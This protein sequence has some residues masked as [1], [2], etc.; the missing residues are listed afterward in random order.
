MKRIALAPLSAEAFAP[1]GDLID[2]R[3]ACE[4]YAING[5]QTRRFHA[6]GRADC[7]TDAGDTIFSIFRSQP[8]SADFKLRT[9][10]RHPLGSQAFI[11]TSGN[12]YAIVVAPAGDLDEDAIRGFIATPQQSINYHRGTWHHFL[13]ALDAPSD[14]VVVDRDGPGENC[15]E[16]DLV[17][18]LLLGLDLEA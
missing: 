15:D 1:F 6:L 7:D 12:R 5:G 16:Q 8:I 4:N 2:T 11:N 9:M 13:L 3:V 17:Q 10:E 18:P 14:F